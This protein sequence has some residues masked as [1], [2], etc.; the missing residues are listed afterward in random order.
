MLTLTR[1]QD[2]DPVALAV[3][4]AVGQVGGYS[5]E[6]LVPQLRLYEDLGFDSVMIMEL[7]NRLEERLTGIGQLTVQDLLPRLSSVGDL[8]SFLCEQGAAVPGHA[9]SGHE[10]R[11]A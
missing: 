2:D 9:V 8:V 4:A 5:G 7:K 3:Q 11:T 1:G 6:D 10:E